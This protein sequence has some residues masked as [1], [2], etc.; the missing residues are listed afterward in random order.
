M[1]WQDMT[2]DTENKKEVAELVT[3][4][5]SLK[6]VANK[7]GEK[8]LIYGGMATGKTHF[9]LTADAPIYI[10]DTELGSAPLKNYP[11]FK[12]KD[13]QVLEVFEPNEEPEQDE[14][15]S[16]ERAKDAIDWVYKN[17]TTGTLIV[18]SITDLWKF[19]QAYAKIKVFKLPA[20]KRFQQQ[21][22]WAVPNA[23]YQ[24]LILKMLAMPLNVI[25]T[26][27]ESEVYEGA[28]KPTGNYVP[29][30]QKNTV[31]MVDLVLRNTK[32]YNKSAGAFFQSTIEKSRFGKELVGKTF[33]NLNF[34][35][36]KGELK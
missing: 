22:D 1:G 23:L 9:A 10:I 20:S 16:Y 21:W 31:Y 5:K 6:D 14:V 24:Q 17:V 2:K 33:E 32:G 7:R 36:L 15:L 13:I 3:S 27:R 28:G 34:E 29:S 4:F 30:C 25:L 8:I 18:D 35:R 19:C 26:A 11:A 12:D